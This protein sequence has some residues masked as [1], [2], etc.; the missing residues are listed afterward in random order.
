VAW[1]P[2]KPIA[3]RLAD[4]AP[5]LVDLYRFTRHPRWEIANWRDWLWSRRRLGWLRQVPSPATDA[6]AVLVVLRREDIF[7]VKSGLMLGAALQLRGVRPVVLANHPRVPR[8]RRY[9]AAFGVDSILYRSDLPPDDGETR[10]IEATADELMARRD[11]FAAT[12]RWVY[13]GHPLGDRVLSTLIREMVS[14][15]PDLTDRAVRAR[16]RRILLQVLRHYHEAERVMRVVD[17]VGVLADETG[18]AVNGPLVDVAIAQGRDVFEASPFLR[19]G[20]LVLK[21]MNLD[22]GRAPCSSVSRASLERL[23]RTPW[24]AELDAEIEAEIEGRY[25]GQESLRKMYQWHTHDVGRDQIC[26]DLGLDPGRPLVVVFSH[27]LWDASFFY[28]Q[29]LFPNYGRWLEET[30]RAAADNARVNWLFKTHPANAFRL[31]HGDVEGPV[32]EV[33]VIERCLDELPP[34]VRLLLPETSI[35]SLALYRHGDVGVTVRG[36]AG[37]EMACFGKPVLTAG[38]GHYSGFGFTLDSTTRGEYLDRLRRIE[39]STAPLADEQRTRAR[40]YAHALFELRP[41][42]ARSFELRL[43]YPDV[44][45]H[46]L[47]RNV[48]PVARSLGEAERLGD[49]HRWAEWAVSSRE[50]DY[51]KDRRR[52]GEAP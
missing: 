50:A 34:H 35:S 44:G 9:A 45:W 20:T 49:L 43:D 6:P 1:P 39:T 14:G 51:L 17:P 13:R 36:T 27:V 48:V 11:D 4:R 46:P 26:A 38:S 21:R 23:E 8:I 41:W 5:W 10:E 16:M 2:S 15:E 24:S 29:D 22:V 25:V 28:G 7:D 33:E 40:R 37:L 18:Y 12:R 30:L 47:D 32:A 42:V 52:G 19:E 3:R 31:A